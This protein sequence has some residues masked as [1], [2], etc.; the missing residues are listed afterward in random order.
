MVLTMDKHPDSLPKAE[1]IIGDK[2][3]SD[4]SH[5]SSLPLPQNMVLKAIGVHCP[6]CLHYHLGWT[7]QMDP[8]IP[9]EVE[10]IEKKCI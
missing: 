8:D 9:D 1:G 10:G 6:W 7:A 4:L 2:G 3:T 5:P